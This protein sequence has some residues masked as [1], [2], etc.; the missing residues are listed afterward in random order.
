MAQ[1]AANRVVQACARRSMRW[2]TTTIVPITAAR[3]TVG[4]APTNRVYSQMQARIGQN[5]LRLEMCNP[6]ARLYNAA[7]MIEIFQPE[8][9]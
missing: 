1:Q 8:N 4:V 9:Q 6:F 7:A 5:A 3:I 2:P